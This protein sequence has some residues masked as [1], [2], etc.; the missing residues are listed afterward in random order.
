MNATCLNNVKFIALV[1]LGASVVTTLACVAS[2]IAGSKCGTE[3]AATPGNGCVNIE[4]VNEYTCSGSTT[5]Y[6][7]YSSSYTANCTKTQLN[8]NTWTDGYGYH[9]SCNGTGYFAG[10]IPAPCKKVTIEMIGCL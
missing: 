2:G 8:L 9:E 5:D 1:F 10:Y 7:C 4:C 6:A 3:H